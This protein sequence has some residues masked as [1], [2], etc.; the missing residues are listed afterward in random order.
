M[1]EKMNILFVGKYPPIVGGESSKLYWLSKALGE[2]GHKCYIVSGGHAKKE[3]KCKI[4]FEDLEFLQPNKNVKFFSLSPLDKTKWNKK[5]L[6]E[7]LTSLGLEVIANEKIDLIVG[8]YLLPYGMVA[9]NLSNFSGKPHVLQHAGSD[10]VRLF[11]DESLKPLLLNIISSAAGIMAYPSYINFFKRVNDNVFLHTPHVDMN[12]FNS[13][14]P[15]NFEDYGLSEIKNRKIIL[16]LGKITKPKGIYELISAYQKL[17]TKNVLLLLVG[18]GKEKINLERNINKKVYFLD[19][20]P[21]W[22]IPGLLKKATITVVPE[23]NF[24]VPH[25]VSRIPLESMVAKTPVIISEEIKSHGLYRLLENEKH[26]IVID[27]KNTESFTNSIDDLLNNQKK[28]IIIK[29][30]Y[31][32]IAKRTNFSNYI[33]NIEN[34]FKS[35]IY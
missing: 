20:I 16:F 26:C 23:N 6:T 14:L 9:H 19:F 12:S 30:A 29:E 35:I 24:G 8:W 2:R 28:D 5:Y 10:M 21:P 3:F 4:K 22:R 31:D 11:S 15:F 13:S 32:F 18:N 7:K 17:K 34:F 33:E 27:P 1:L 25:H